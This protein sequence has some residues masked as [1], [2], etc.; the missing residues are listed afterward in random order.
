MTFNDCLALGIHEWCDNVVKIAD[1]ASKEYTIEDTLTKMEG[2]WEHNEL[3]LTAYK[4]TGRY[5]VI[6]CRM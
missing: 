1:S 6:E 5:A 4:N 3:D 2:E